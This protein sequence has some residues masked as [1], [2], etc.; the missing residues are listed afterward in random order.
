MPTLAIQTD[1][2]TQARELEVEQ[3]ALERDRYAELFELAPEAYLVTDP[4]GII[5]EA[6]AAASRLL[7]VAAQSLRAKA[8]D[9]FIPLEQRRVFRGRLAAL[10]ASG[11]IERTTWRAGL[12]CARTDV[13]IEFTVG[14]IKHRALP[15]FSLCWLLRPL[16]AESPAYFT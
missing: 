11:G 10:A 6:N 3:L 14:C 12:R 16:Q 5:L 4:Y 1:E 2:R 9:L 8:L 13:S 7:A 15:M